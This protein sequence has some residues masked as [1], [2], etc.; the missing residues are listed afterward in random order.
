MPSGGKRPNAGRKKGQ[1]DSP[2]AHLQ[3]L[4][5]PHAAKAI[6]ALIGNLTDENASVRNI[7][8][9]EILDRAYGK[10]PI[11]I[12]GEDGGDIQVTIKK[13]IHSATD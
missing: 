2:K 7:A 4:M 8:A 9:K 6:K 3:K 13:I 5:K 10:S 12:T 1:A 11:A